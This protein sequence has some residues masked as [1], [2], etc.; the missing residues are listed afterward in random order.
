[1]HIYGS[2]LIR[3]EYGKPAGARIECVLAEVAGSLQDCLSNC[4][5]SC[6]ACKIWHLYVYIEG[7]ANLTLKHMGYNGRC[8]YAHTLQLYAVLLYSFELIDVLLSIG[9][10]HSRCIQLV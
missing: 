3:V 10:P 8:C 7:S 1:M 6:T 5:E 9:A 2:F 4:N